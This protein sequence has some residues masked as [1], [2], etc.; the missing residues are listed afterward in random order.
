[1]TN[2]EVELLAIGAGPSNLALAVALEEL[3]PDLAQNSLVIERGHDIA[4]QQGLLLPWV[5]S[6][7]SFLK[8]LVTLR[9]PCSKF[10]FLNYLHDVGRLDDFV[11]MG[12]F[13]P[14]RLEIAEY[15]AWAAK[16]LTQVRLELGRECVSVEPCRDAQGMVTGWLTGLADGS[17]ITSRYLVVG[18]GRDPYV[19]PVLRGVPEQRIIHSTQYRYRVAKLSAE[20]PYR[21]AVVGSAQSAA[22]MVQSLQTDLPD[23]DIAWIMRSISLRSY[24]ANNKFT[25]EFYY[26]SFI[27][28]FFEARPEGREQILEEMHRTNYSGVAPGLLESLYNDHYLDRLTGRRGKQMIAMTD[29]TGAREIDDEI[30]LELT[31]RRTGEVSELRRDL[32]FLGTGFVREM[33]TLVRGLAS[34]LG[35]DRVSVNRRYR[36]DLGGPATAACYLQGVNE[37]THGIADSLLSVLA[38]RAEDVTRD[39]LAHRRHAS[40]GH[41]NGA[42]QGDIGQTLPLATDGG[43]VPLPV[44]TD[45]GGVARA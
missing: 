37:A 29:I 18:A 3:C 28:A 33:P 19:P 9:N 23:C 44:T 32:V 11:N 30:A 43:G 41:H 8:D 21:V 5:K 36:M 34:R 35:L 38:S 2:R 39:I 4:W 7:V 13:T 17:T 27:D 6:Q 42:H 26:P 31:D 12:N 25:N 22:E 24:E 20:L 14:Y 15:F 16:M 45:A 40:N 10:S 1:M